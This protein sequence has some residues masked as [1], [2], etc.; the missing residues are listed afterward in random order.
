[1]S[2]QR[3]TVQELIDK[4]E[5]ARIK[6]LKDK[7]DFISKNMATTDMY[8]RIPESVFVNYFLPFFIGQ[9]QSDT[10]VIEWISI[11]GTPMLPVYV[12]DDVTK[13]ILYTVPGYLDTSGII[14]DNKNLS[15]SAIIERYIMIENNGIPMQSR[16]F[17]A[18]NLNEYEKAITGDISRNTINQWYHIL[19]RYNLLPQ[20]S[21]TVSNPNNS[22]DDFIDG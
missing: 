18:K 9:R 19:Q 15:L 1:M 3:D 20:A 14:N 2:I 13:E 21:E 17:L 12:I 6:D 16:A 4:E 5:Q 7:A 10:W 8:N 22:L 11:A